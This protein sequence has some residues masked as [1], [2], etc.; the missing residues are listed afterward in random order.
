VLPGNLLHA[1]APDT[2]VFVRLVP[3]IGGTIRVRTRVDR[4]V[5]GAR[6]AH[7]E[8]PAADLADAM[9]RTCRALTMR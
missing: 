4:A 6:I 8:I 9:Q 2:H 7:V 1:G 3:P 5:T